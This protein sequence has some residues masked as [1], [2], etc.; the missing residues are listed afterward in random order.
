[1]ETILTSEIPEV[2]DEDIIKA[3]LDIGEEDVIGFIAK[4]V[5]EKSGDANFI[6]KLSKDV[7]D[8]YKIAAEVEVQNGAKTPPLNRQTQRQIERIEVLKNSS[9]KLTPKQ[10]EELRRLEYAVNNAKTRAAAMA[11]EVAKMNYEENLAKINSLSAEEKMAFV[12]DAYRYKPEVYDELIKRL[13]DTYSGGIKNASFETVE[14]IAKACGTINYE[15]DKSKY[16][17]NFMMIADFSNANKII[18]NAIFELH[19]KKTPSFHSCGDNGNYMMKMRKCS[20]M[21][22]RT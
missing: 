6:T 22:Q 17:D 8:L 20:L 4:H 16:V 9:E 7:D 14:E 13:G 19:N 15:N 1:M 10:K 12:K 11:D 3:D 21:Q 2:I 18:F 5:D